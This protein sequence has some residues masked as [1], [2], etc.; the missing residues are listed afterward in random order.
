MEGCDWTYKQYTREY[1]RRKVVRP[2][3]QRYLQEAAARRTASLAASAC[4]SAAVAEQSGVASLALP[5]PAAAAPQVCLADEQQQGSQ[6]AAVAAVQAAQEEAGWQPR[7]VLA[8]AVL[9]PMPEAAGPMLLCEQAEQG[10]E[11]EMADAGATVD[12]AAAEEQQLEEEEEEGEGQL[13]S[14]PAL[15]PALSAI[16]P[17]G[18]EPITPAAAMRAAA[19]KQPEPSGGVRTPGVMTPERVKEV[20]QL[21]LVW[22]CKQRA[23]ASAAHASP[24]PTLKCLLAGAWRLPFSV[25]V[26]PPRAPLLF[27][28][29]CKY[30][31]LM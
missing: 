31:C 8:P 13:A 2:V 20:G 28:N 10:D 22:S 21:A 6:A 30:G 4:D 26:H 16:K 29:R 12:A 27:L 1:V 3:E 17:A 7:P 11:G 5:E 18:G 23:H 19:G 24:W 14:L 15:Q 25:S 9:Q